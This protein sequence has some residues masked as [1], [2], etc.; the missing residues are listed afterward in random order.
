MQFIRSNKTCG[1]VQMTWAGINSFSF[2]SKRVYADPRLN[3]F[4][5]FFFLGKEYLKRVLRS[6]DL[7]SL[8]RA[9]IYIYILSTPFS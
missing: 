5:F 4:F 2:L 7:P 8:D 1:G 9:R 6:H 3:F